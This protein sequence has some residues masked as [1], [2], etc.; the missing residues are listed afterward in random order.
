MKAI[1]FLQLLGETPE[2]YV[3]D[4]TDGTA[5]R[6]P[7]K[8]IW[9]IASIVALML[10]LVGCAVVYMLRMQ[11]LTVG[12]WSD[13]I[14]IIFDENGNQIP[15]E[16][17]EPTILLSQ[18]NA[19]IEA[20]TEWLA[21]TDAYD[22]DGSIMAEADMALKSGNPWDLPENYHYTYG[23][24][25]QE[26]VDKLDE[27]VE[28]Y[29]LKLL[30]TSETFMYY[31]SKAM[32]NCM[33]LDSLTHDD[34]GVEYWGGYL[35]PEGT[36]IMDLELKL[37]MDGWSTREGN[38]SRYRYSVKEYFDPFTGGMK[39]SQT[40]TQWNYTRGDGLTVLLILNEETARIYVDL[41]EAFVSISVDP[42]ILVDGEEVPMTQEVL[43]Q[44][45]EF[46]DL[47][48]KPQATTVENIRKS[49]E[50]SQVAFDAEKAQQQAKD[51]LQYAAGYE[52]YVKYR[53]EK[54]LFPE[55]MSYI[56]W[57]VNGDSIKELIIGGSTILSMR[58]GESY[59]YFSISD[60]A[61]IGGSF[62]PCEGNI[63]EIY[64]VYDFVS[65]DDYF[66]YQAGPEG[67]EFITGL[68]HDTGTDTWY[69]Y[70][71][72]SLEAEKK[73][74]SSE[75]AEKIL[76]EF[77]RLKVDWLPLVKYGQPVT[78]VNYTETYSKYIADKLDRYGEAVGYTYTLMDLDGDG[79]EEL[80]TRDAISEIAGERH[81]L[82]NI[83]TIRDGEL[84]Y[85]ETL[86]ISNICEGGIL[87]SAEDFV[88]SE[89]RKDFHAYYRY[90]GNEIELIEAIRREPISKY[91]SHRVE[92][93]DYQPV[94][95]EKAQSIIS[96]YKRIDLDMKP[97]TEYPFQ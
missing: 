58:D 93:G 82:L 1:E 56:L 75:E 88:Q 59:N 97:F 16:T 74:I 81:L 34:T 27:I 35:F 94:S 91:W 63:F 50:E 42:V 7:P 55:M 13:E 77:A 20:L 29:D 15:I 8:R 49:L 60:S 40:Y 23:C 4:V 25:S 92:D 11:D 95:E 46:F 57:D 14:P 2:A 64:S 37:D 32:L 52:E 96:S 18:Q 69:Q 45:A 89:D 21:F 54:A 22:P 78:S 38:F 30:S 51:E 66:F 72:D 84:V 68:T 5:V 24:Y 85:L 26:L 48:A 86:G 76:D 41:P 87:E 31:Q 43:E 83:H 44:I 70:L 6:K 67:A 62:R 90:T 71:T 79:Q 3:L 10:V 65:T 80:I 73:V 33:G 9:L 17:R 47:S 19:N 53:L 36:L 39:A 12:Q 28:K 61:V